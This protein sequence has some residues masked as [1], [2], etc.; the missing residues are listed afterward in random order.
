MHNGLELGRP[1]RHKRV[2]LAVLA[3]AGFLALWWGLPRL[4]A[5]LP[6]GGQTFREALGN[7]LSPHY[8]AELT[9][10]QEQ[11]ADLHHRLAL[12]ETALAENEAMRRLL[13]CQR[14]EGSWQPAR[15]VARYPEGVLLACSG[16]ETAPVTDSLGRY[17]GRVTTANRDGTCLV[18]FAG[19]ED[20]PCAGLSGTSAGLLHRDKDWQLS[21][22]P[23][24]CGLTAGSVV[25][26]PEGYWLGVLSAPPVPDP[27]GLTATAAL[28]DTADLSATIFFVKCKN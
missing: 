19:S 24:D 9:A 27:D 10:L 13:G 3:A 7:W 23:A 6:A 26:T 14:P 17:A 16:W 20:A 5:A 8:S 11:N 4:A 2:W 15:V 18:S 1:R 25:T 28:T 12:A 22:L 21:G